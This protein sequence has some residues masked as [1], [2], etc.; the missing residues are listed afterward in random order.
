[1]KCVKVKVNL[2]WDVPKGTRGKVITAIVTNGDTEYV[3]FHQSRRIERISTKYLE[4]DTD[5]CAT[6]NERFVCFTE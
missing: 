2:F 5:N 3:R 1:M 6:C 4:S